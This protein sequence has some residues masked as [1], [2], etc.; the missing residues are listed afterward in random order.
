[1]EKLENWVLFKR[2]T[3]GALALACNICFL[4]IIEYPKK[5]DMMMSGLGM[6]AF[7]C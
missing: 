7:I 5:S 3:T 4:D 2:G 1:M 6:I